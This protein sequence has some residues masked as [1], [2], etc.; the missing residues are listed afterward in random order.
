MGG[1]PK[2][3]PPLAFA[4]L[5]AYSAATTRLPPREDTIRHFS[6]AREGKIK[7][8]SRTPRPVERQR[9]RFLEAKTSSAK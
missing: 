4:Q 9:F 6:H 1:V 2:G 8:L 3:V 7:R 5:S